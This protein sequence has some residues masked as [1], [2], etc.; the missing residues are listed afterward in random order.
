MSFQKKKIK[1]Q[2]PWFWEWFP[3]CGAVARAAQLAVEAHEAR[4]LL[5]PGGGVSN[6]AA[7]LQLRWLPPRPF[8]PLPE[9]HN[10]E[11]MAGAR[12]SPAAQLC[13]T[14]EERE[15]TSRKNGAR[16]L[17]DWSKEAG[18]MATKARAQDPRWWNESP[19]WGCHRASSFHA[20][21]TF[22]FSLLKSCKDSSFTDMSSYLICI[23]L[24]EMSIE[25]DLN[26]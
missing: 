23:N 17:E 20:H 4:K 15:R 19:Q 16:R 6:E 12:F 18:R 22:L 25:T 14:G 13:S 1:G 10:E 3:Y 26:S 2:L 8:P 21:E 24:H 5:A 11:D 9:L 7:F